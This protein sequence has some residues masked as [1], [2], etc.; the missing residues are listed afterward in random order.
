MTPEQFKELLI[1]LRSMAEKNYT[2][3][4]AADWPMLAFLLGVI[5]VLIALMW[6]DLKRTLRDNQEEHKLLWKS[7]GDCQ[8]DC[9]PRGRG[10]KR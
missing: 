4:Q 8:D 3:T 10:E 6:A 7:L 5:G 2:L 1:V 9:C